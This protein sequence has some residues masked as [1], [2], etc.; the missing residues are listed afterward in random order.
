MNV[1]RLRVIFL[2]TCAASVLLCCCSAYLLY[3]NFLSYQH[4]KQ[5][6]AD[7]S[8]QLYQLTTEYDWVRANSS[9]YQQLHDSGVV[10]VSDSL[11]W[12]DLL[13]FAGK[14]LD[15]KNL[16]FEFSPVVAVSGPGDMTTE[17]VEISI[18]GNL[19]HDGVL[20]QLFTLLAEHTSRAWYFEAM[21]VSRVHQ[22]VDTSLDE[23]D[24]F[25]TN[26]SLTFVLKLVWLVLVPKGAGSAVI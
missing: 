5:T 25:D 7:N 14:Q 17:Q 21:D 9:Y 11:I 10:G 12:I 19:L 8:R 3:R 20:M 26:E 4:L 18:R 23:G 22:T 13:A 15:I 16:Q 24:P 1:R 2:L 6:Y